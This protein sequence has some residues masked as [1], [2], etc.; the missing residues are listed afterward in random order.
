MYLV[1]SHV[2]VTPWRKTHGIIQMWIIPN[3]WYFSMRLEQF[4][5]PI[6]FEKGEE[7]HFTEINPTTQISSNISSLFFYYMEWILVL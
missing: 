3:E 4:I 5:L 7:M 2:S 6:E 1:A